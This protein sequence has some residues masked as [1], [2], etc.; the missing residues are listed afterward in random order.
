MCHL[1]VSGGDSG[2]MWDCIDRTEPFTVVVEDC[3]SIGRAFGGVV[4][5]LSRTEEPVCFRRCC[6]WSLDW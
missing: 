4:S 5:C 2:L 6:L 1:Y 3:G